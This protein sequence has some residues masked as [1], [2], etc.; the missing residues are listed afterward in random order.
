M[1]VSILQ[2]KAHLIARNAETGAILKQATAINILQGAK[3]KVAGIRMGLIGI[4]TKSLKAL[5]GETLGSIRLAFSLNKL[6][7]AKLLVAGAAKK[8]K[9]AFL[10]AGKAILAMMAKLLISPLGLILALGSII[11]ALKKISEATDTTNPTIAE[12]QIRIKKASAALK[13]I[14]EGIKEFFGRII[15]GEGILGKFFKV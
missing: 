5:T 14:I 13:E 8:M 1:G 6:T 2:S 3:N 11:I 12:F 10:A 4:M 9:V 15:R 7:A